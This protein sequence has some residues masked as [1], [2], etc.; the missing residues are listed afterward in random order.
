MMRLPIRNYTFFGLEPNLVI[1]TFWVTGLCPNFTCALGDFIM[2][3]VRVGI[4]VIEF[5]VRVGR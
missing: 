2:V 4:E 1:A 3:G 5:R